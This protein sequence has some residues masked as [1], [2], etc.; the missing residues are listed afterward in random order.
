MRIAIAALLTCLL[1]TGC[2]RSG[3]PTAPLAPARK[4]LASA[5]SSIGADL[6]ANDSSV[7]VTD[8]NGETPG[9]VLLLFIRAKNSSD[10]KG[11]Y[12]LYASPEADFEQFVAEAELTAERFDEFEVRE[13][14]IVDGETALVRATYTAETT[15]P[16]GKA[17]AV[18]VGEPGR[19][20][21]MEMSDGLWRVRWRA[22]Q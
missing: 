5:S 14:R 11:A 21:A 19:W 2:T 3:G 17:Y 4:P 16:D 6:P 8:R 20:W 18:E 15:P 10:W 1:L 9:E 12:A 13:V 7:S 22:V